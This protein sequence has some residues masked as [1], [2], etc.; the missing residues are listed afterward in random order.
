MRSRGRAGHPAARVGL[1]CAIYTRK[2]SEEGLEQEFN[3][4]DAQREACE[5]Y[6]RSQ[7]HE[8]WA[9]LP[10]LY[11]DG[12]L[13]GGSLNRPALQRVLAD[14]A[15]G[16]VDLVVV[17]KVDRLTRS[18]SDFAK[19]VEVLDG[20]GASFVS[21][22]QQFNTTTSMGRLTLNMLL[23]FA[24][25]EREVT[26]ERIR[27]KIAASKRKGMWMGGS[28]P[29]GYDVHERKLI[30]NAT[31]ADGVRRIYRAYLDLGTVRLAKQC[32]AAEGITGKAGS[33]LGRGALF[34]MLQNRTYRGEVEHQGDVYPGQHEAIVEAELWAAV[35]QR[36][37]KGRADHRSGA[38]AR[39]PSLLAGMIADTAGEAMAATHANKGGRRYRYYV[40]R[41]PIDGVRDDYPDALRV[42]AAALERVVAGRIAR[43]LS[44]G[45]EL[46][47]ALRSAGAL[48][49]D[50]AQQRRLLDGAQA[51][52]RNLQDGALV[53]QRER[54]L[55]LGAAITVG[56]QEITIDL[57]PSGLVAVLAGEPR[58]DTA[59][60]THDGQRQHP[61]ICLTE[62]VALRRTGREMVLL[63][64]ATVAGDR[65]DASLAR[66]V[67]KAWALREALACSTSPSL[68]AFAAKQAI[69]QSYATRLIRL[70][71]LAPD[72]V[73]AILGGCQPSNL[74]ASRLMR[75][76]RIPSDWQEQ[77]RMLGFT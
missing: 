61:S 71:W 52:G 57:C 12:G 65:A 24:Q 2:S 66:L 27:D 74:T 56:R 32:L 31:E 37:S 14:V 7:R 54:L 13:S 25:F 20:H 18:L 6:I 22:T 16:R 36:L 70:A 49:S 45:P 9:L 21:V 77:R 73:E 48:P 55:C 10:A 42:P 60:D 29:L 69:S 72:I 40:S 5:A 50:G 63:V 64:G 39:H 34:H 46:L 3:S 4:L 35:Q 33:P 1:R 67:A 43:L 19:I 8:G 44:D 30:I 38:N 53:G 51:I 76:T 41:I 11:D 23:S 58:G 17:Y 26:G 75:D 68:T 59:A 62:P 28:V 47:R 15:S